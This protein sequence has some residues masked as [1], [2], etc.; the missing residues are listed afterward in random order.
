MMSLEELGLRRG[1]PV[2]GFGIVTSVGSRNH[3]GV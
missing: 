1:L 2:N 3:A